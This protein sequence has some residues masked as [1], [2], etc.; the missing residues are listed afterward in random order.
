MK[1][2]NKIEIFNIPELITCK[3]CMGKYRQITNTHLKRHNLKM[4]DYKRK[5]PNAILVGS[6]TRKK[7][8]EIQENAWK[9]NDKRIVTPSHLKEYLKNKNIKAKCDFYNALVQGLPYRK[10]QQS[11]NMKKI[12]KNPKFK[13]IQ[14]LGR[15]QVIKNRYKVYEDNIDLVIELY[16]KGY[17]SKK[18]SKKIGV[19]FTTILNWLK[20][21]GINN[22]QKG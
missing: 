12:C 1:L 13:K 8:S 16:K 9:N 19:S 11:D 3:I 15:N 17:G 21:S 4:K 18:I 6:K 14:E 5:Y 7:L 22:K 10:K 20:K 2:E